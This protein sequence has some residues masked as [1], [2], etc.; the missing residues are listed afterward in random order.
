MLDFR[1]KCP[2]NTCTKTFSNYRSYKFPWLRNDYHERCGYCN[3]HDSWSGGRRGMQIDHFAPKKKFRAL[4]NIY[5]NLVYSCFYCNNSKSD[6]WV[7]K[8]PNQ[9]ISR[10]G[11]TGYIHPR[12]TNYDSAFKRDNKGNIQPQSDV[13]RYMY[14]ELCLGL[15]RHSLIF[16]LE[17]LEKLWVEAKSAI[18]GGNLDAKTLTRLNDKKRDLADR[19]MDLLQEYKTELN[20]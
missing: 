15:K 7:T 13:A 11:T 1:D 18:Q 4:E 2:T 20:N 10:L 16:R 14:K 8:K 9:P 17:L 12:E 6:D 5:D 3:D 19:F